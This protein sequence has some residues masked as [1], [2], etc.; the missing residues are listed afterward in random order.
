MSELDP[1]QLTEAMLKVQMRQA[2]QVQ[3]AAWMDAVL[4]LLK[5]EFGFTEGQ[6]A[7]FGRRF[8]EET[9]AQKAAQDQAKADS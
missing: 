8:M 2:V 7:T 5:E 1:Q 4:R 6:L 3:L 9:R